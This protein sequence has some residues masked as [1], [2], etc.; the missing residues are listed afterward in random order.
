MKTALCL[1]QTEW[2]APET[3]KK[4]ASPYYV[5]RFSYTNDILTVEYLNQDV[6]DSD[7]KDSAPLR[8]AVLANRSNPDLFGDPGRF[9]KLDD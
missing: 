9:R 3:D 1:I 2:R 4:D 5:C 6:V 8:D 7:I